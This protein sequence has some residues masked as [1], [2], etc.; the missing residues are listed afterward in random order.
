MASQIR[1][2]LSEN[3][4]R[5]RSEI[6]Q[7]VI[8]D[9]FNLVLIRYMQ[10]HGKGLELISGKKTAESNTWSIEVTRFCA[11]PENSHRPT[12]NCRDICFS[13]KNDNVT[14]LLLWKS[15]PS[16]YYQ[17]TTFIIHMSSFTFIKCSN[18]SLC[19]LCL[20]L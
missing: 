13:E 9:N 4:L 16:D 6:T 3:G 19:M 15:K 1:W 7:G 2:L 14:E 17:P 20:H 12:L 8:A 10:K 5:D 18:I 11:F